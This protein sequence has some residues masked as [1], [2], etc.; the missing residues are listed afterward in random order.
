[1]ALLSYDDELFLE[2]IIKVRTYHDNTCTMYLKL[3]NSK[4]RFV[5]ICT[6]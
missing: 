4:S 1:M 6:L 2:R 3:S 5:M